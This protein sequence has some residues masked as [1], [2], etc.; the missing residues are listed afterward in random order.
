MKI[1]GR[2][3]HRIAWATSVCLLLGA[4]LDSD[5]YSVDGLEASPNLLL[6]LASGV[7]GVEDFLPD[8]DTAL[9]HVDANGLVYLS[10]GQTL[11]SQDISDLLAFPDKSFLKTVPLPPAVVPPSATDQPY[12]TLSTTL[13]FGLDPEKLTEM[14]LKGG[15]LRIST[16]LVPFD[17][18]GFNYEVRVELPDVTRGNDPFAI[19][20][21][22]KPLNVGLQNYRMLFNDNITTLK[23]TVIQKAHSNS[24]VVPVGAEL[25][26]ELAF[27]AMDYSI[28][29]G[30]MGDQVASIP[31]Q[32]INIEAFDPLPGADA[33]FV[34][35][36]LA[37]EVLNRYGI[38]VN[39]N[40]LQLE[41]RKKGHAPLLLQLDK[42]SPIEIGF[43][44]QPG[45]SSTT[46]VN[47]LNAKALL[48]FDPDQFY[49]RINARINEGLT[50]GDNFCEDVSELKIRFKA[51]L[52][53]YG[54]AS[55]I[56]LGDTVDLDLE[57][58]EQ[59][60][61]EDF[62]IR[63]KIKN[64]LPLEGTL[65]FYLVDRNNHV[66]DSIFTTAQSALVKGSTVNA[67]GELVSAGVFDQEFPIEKSKVDKLF[68]ASRLIILS[69]MNTVKAPNGTQPDVKF[70]ASYKM[71]VK[72][73]V[74]ATLNVKADL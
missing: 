74:R 26:V 31:E 11:H 24:V 61:I 17:L 34:E 22:G 55:K 49:Y 72:L 48:D 33:S 16:T 56:V 47:V 9:V 7:L 67:A 13:D 69:R 63:A 12:A 70:K 44:T 1:S 45:D 18:A 6:P 64:D 36:R 32:S 59:S 54:H 38:P 71:D 66:I 35:P 68:Q 43:P 65:Q 28:A 30:F 37:F 53:L 19:T 46:V 20:A 62:F 3:G 15:N 42:T 58:V 50:T 52:P 8:A 27:T 5:D 41:A 39:V 21:S 73:G 57:D 4:C 40:F 10:Y 60:N 51:D 2:F 29:R 23:L 14:I 25:K